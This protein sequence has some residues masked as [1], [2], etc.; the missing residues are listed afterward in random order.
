MRFNQDPAQGTIPVPNTVETAFTLQSIASSMGDPSTYPPMIDAFNHLFT[1]GFR[2]Q[3]S[4][5]LAFK[6]MEALRRAQDYYRMRIA[7]C[8]GEGYQ[9]VA[10]YDS[11]E[12]RVQFKP[13]SWVWGLYVPTVGL[14]SGYKQG[15]Q[16]L[17]G[18]T[19]D[20]V[21][22]RTAITVTGLGQYNN[23]GASSY[24][25]LI[26]PPLLASGDGSI[27]VTLAN[28]D[29]QNNMRLILFVAEPKA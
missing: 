22:S 5:M 1:Y 23:F 29:V 3:Y 18:K 28:A 25:S 14:G 20:P 17:I 12:W 19:Q 8:P 9:T 24:V 10:A 6:R 21:F 27:A 7:V 26:D 4:T 16:I 11:T 15:V 13:G 2:N